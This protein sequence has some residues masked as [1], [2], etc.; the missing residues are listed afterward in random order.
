M[1]NFIPLFPLS[2]VVYPGE[3][4]NLHIFE[5]RY[6]QMINDCATQ[7]KPFG[8][9][10]VIDNK[11]TDWGTLLMVTEVFKRYD[12]GEMDIKTKGIEVFN[13]LE[14]IHQL[15]DKLYSGAIV[16]Y[17]P[18]NNHS[19]SSLKSKVIENT[20]LLHH[21]LKVQKPLPEE[22]EQINSYLIAHH[23]GLKLEEELDVLTY[24]DE[25][26]RLEYLNRH[27][28]KVIP[29]AKEMESLKEKIKLNGHFKHISGYEAQ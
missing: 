29:V 24:M 18:N 1:T 5:P 21:I 23:I 9:Q 19:K 27:L 10:V 6:I 20:R 2:I 12:S 25:N 7:N 26:H 4:L 16:N 13:I 3:N 17:P 14:P 11:P 22:E 28:K 15:P 8:L